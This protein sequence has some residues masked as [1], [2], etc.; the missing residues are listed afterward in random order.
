VK[1][2]SFVR[3][4][5]VQAAASERGNVRRFIAWAEAADDDELADAA[6]ML[7]G[8]LLGGALP[9]ELRRDLEIC[10]TLIIEHAS[11]PVRR[12]LADA[13]ADANNAPLHIIMALADDEP[14][15][16]SLVLARSPL[17]GEAELIE[18]A[19]N[20]E[21]RLQIAL[22]RRSGLPARVAAFLAEIG[23]S[24]VTIAL[25]ENRQAHV[26]PAALRRIA[27]RF[28]DD[29][30]VRAALLARPEL[31]PT[32]RYDLVEATTKAQSVPGGPELAPA[33]IERMGR[34]AGER[35]AIRVASLCEPSDVR[36]L[37]RHLRIQGALTAALLTRALVSGG[38]AFFEAAA[39]EL[40]GLAPERVEALVSDSGG[41]G[42]EALYRRMGLPAHLL[43]PFRVALDAI[44]EFGG[45]SADGASQPIVSRVIAACDR[46]ARPELGKLVS[47]LR[48]LETEAALADARAFVAGIAAEFTARRGR[49]KR[50][51]P[52]R[53]VS[54]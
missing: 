49:D 54:V 43:A 51:R 3:V 22:A 17:L 15:I 19:A 32:L 44:E 10:L 26:S 9:G 39:A 40:S 25:L 37:V 52:S 11:P 4:S 41:A 14:E 30:V 1:L 8:A 35:N 33:R 45:E 16:A 31:P 34:D 13:I 6:I 50:C 53:R 2:V 18:Y 12:A 21:A 36:D 38:R 7:A 48:R 47:L 46:L 29:E 24:D 42:F 20:G 23:Q 28:M 27:E 5:R